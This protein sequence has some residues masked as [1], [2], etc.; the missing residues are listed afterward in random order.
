MSVSAMASIPKPRISCRE[1]K[2][3]KRKEGRTEGERK[4]IEL[5]GEQGKNKNNHKEDRPVSNTANQFV[6]RRVH[7]VVLC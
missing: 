2:R 6:V 7:R 4:H 5:R 3:E 1:K